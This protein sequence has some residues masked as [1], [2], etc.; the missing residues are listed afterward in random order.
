MASDSE[1]AA[2]FKDDGLAPFEDEPDGTSALLA[3]EGGELQVE[4]DPSLRPPH[5]SCKA[6]VGSLFVLTA[7]VGGGGLAWNAMELQAERD[8][9]EVYHA[10]R[11]RVLK[12]LARGEERRRQQQ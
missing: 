8:R 1:V 12:Y 2:E 4:R 5:H 9:V 6:W 11:Q 7:L 10:T 3:R